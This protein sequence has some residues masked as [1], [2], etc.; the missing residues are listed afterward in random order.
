MREVGRANE[1]GALSCEDRRDVV[2]LVCAVVASWVVHEVV[3]VDTTETLVV[4]VGVVVEELWCVR[5]KKTA[6][7]VAVAIVAAE[8]VEGAGDVVVERE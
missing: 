7:V 6:T 2:V 8:A 1:V 4:D 5:M 3:V